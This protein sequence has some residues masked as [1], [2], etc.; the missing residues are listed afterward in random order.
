MV[1]YYTTSERLPNGDPWIRGTNN[2]YDTKPMRVINIGDKFANPIKKELEPDINAYVSI[3][4]QGNVT[5]YQRDNRTGL[6]KLVR[7]YRFSKHGMATKFK[8]F[9]DSLH[10]SKEI[11]NELL[12]DIPNQTKINAILDGRNVNEL[13]N[14]KHMNEKYY[15]KGMCPFDGISCDLNQPFVAG[16]E[17]T[18]PMI[19]EPGIDKCGLDKWKSKNW[20]PAIHISTLKSKKGETAYGDSPPCSKMREFRKKK[21][22]L[23]LKRKSIKKPIKKIKRCI[24]KKK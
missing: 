6:I 1:V 8:T 22:S 4:P 23:K 10:A 16:S 24:C 3:S 15:V 11:A 13:Y 7:Q 20:N 9:D 17:N 21:M 5:H 18:I 2:P 19:K 14:L 12:S